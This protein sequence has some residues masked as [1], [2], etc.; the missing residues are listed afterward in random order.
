MRRWL[1]AI[2]KALTLAGLL[3]LAIADA[4]EVLRS[5]TCRFL[6]QNDE[7]LALEFSHWGV[8]GRNDVVFASTEP[9]QW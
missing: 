5:E 4:S 2:H 1:T 9:V 3:R 8:F 6:A 7:P